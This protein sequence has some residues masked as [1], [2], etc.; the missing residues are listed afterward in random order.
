MKH[1]GTLVQY[2]G[3]GADA[4]RKLKVSNSSKP[5]NSDSIKKFAASIL[6]ENGDQLDVLHSGVIKKKV[7]K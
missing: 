1:A 6:K 5:V 7:G 4:A 3:P 2:S